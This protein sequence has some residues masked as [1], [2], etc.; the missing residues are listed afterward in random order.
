MHSAAVDLVVAA[1]AATMDVATLA[2]A[3][4]CY[5]RAGRH[6]DVAGIF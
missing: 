5:E 3:M 4:S 1:L 6:A 2:C